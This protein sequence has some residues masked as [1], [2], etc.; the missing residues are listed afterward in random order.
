MIITDKFLDVYI[1]TKSLKVCNPGDV[2]SIVYISPQPNI[3]FLYFCT[4]VIV[5]YTNIHCY[6]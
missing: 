3:L 4:L 5:L 1:D 6:S 2:K